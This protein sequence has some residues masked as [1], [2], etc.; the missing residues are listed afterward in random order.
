MLIM[1]HLLGAL[2]VDLDVSL[3]GRL[4]LCIAAART[5][6]LVGRFSY[7]RSDRDRRWC[8]QLNDIE[9]RA[10]FNNDNNGLYNSNLISCT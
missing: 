5:C 7:N 9:G 6:N 4:M 8:S 10:T 3:A 2:L 1:N